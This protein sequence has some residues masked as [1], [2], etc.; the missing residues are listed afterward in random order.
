MN[1]PLSDLP[2]GPLGDSELT[3]VERVDH[4]GDGFAEVGGGLAGTNSGAVLPGGIDKGLELGGV[5]GDSG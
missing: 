3:A 4:L 5:H 1:D 2:L